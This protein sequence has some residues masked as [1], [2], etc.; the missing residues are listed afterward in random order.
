MRHCHQHHFQYLVADLQVESNL[1]LPRL[2]A[3]TIIWRRG[4]SV[5]STR[6]WLGT[7]KEPA[8]SSG[9]GN[10]AIGHQQ[11]GVRRYYSFRERSQ[12]ESGLFSTARRS[13]WPLLRWRGLLTPSNVSR[14]PARSPAFP[15][16]RALYGAV[17]ASAAPPGLI[18]NAEDN[19]S[20]N[21][22]KLFPN[23]PPP[24][25]RSNLLT[26]ARQRASVAEVYSIAVS[27]VA[28]C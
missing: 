5:S 1:T 21:A 17:M 20:A 6:T 18:S 22:A 23:G 14:S 3:T 13:S 11:V 10:N 27:D 24:Q 25:N 9:Y 19:P 4:S 15:T 2:R 16:T 12:G 28:L 8:P 7:V 26:I